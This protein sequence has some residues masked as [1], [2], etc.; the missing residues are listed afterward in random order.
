MTLKRAISN[1][2]RFGGCYIAEQGDISFYLRDGLGQYGEEIG[3]LVCNHN[4]DVPHA[5]LS[6][7]D[8]SVQDLNFKRLKD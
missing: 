3:I 8:E 5:D 7:Y 1:I 2:E 6:I 4:T